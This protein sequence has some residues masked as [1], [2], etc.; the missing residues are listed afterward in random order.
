MKALFVYPEFPDTFWSFRHALKFVSKRASLPPLGLLTVAAMVP[1]HWEKRLVD[2]NV[3]RLR[4]RDIAWADCVFVSAMAV[5]R[6]AAQRLIARCQRAGKRVVAGGPLFTAE[7]EAFPEPDHLVLGEAE[8]A[9]PELVADLERGEARRVYIAPAFPELDRTPVP[10]WRLADLSRYATLSLQYSRGCPFNC[11][12][13]NVTALFGHRPRT[14]SA[15]QVI[16][17]LDALYGAGWRGGVFFV[18]DNLIGNKH[19]LKA[20]L[21]PALIAW[22][23]EHAISGFLTEASIN[24]ADDPELMD[25]MVRAGFTTVFVGIET[26]DA[27][28]LAECSKSQNAN[29]DLVADVKRIQRAGLQVQGGFIVG[30]DSDTPSIF[31]RQIAFIQQSG[32][33]TAMVGLLEALPG[34]RLFERLQREG[35]IAGATSGDNVDGTTNILPRMGLDTLREGYRRI[36]AHIYSPKHYY[37]RLKTF[38]CEYQPPKLRN[39]VTLADLR[40]FV[41]SIVRLGILGSER[42]HYWKLIVWTVLR[43][44]ELLSTAVTLAI[45]GHHF[46]KVCRLH[47]L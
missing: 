44:P 33:V 43:R 45:Y 32:I 11:D 20:E 18:D 21:L 25:L 23:R 31:E 2:L 19:R 27:A 24:L 4:D 36:L 47:V 9:L 46:R 30:F 10:L 39:R 6:A 40:A 41:R 8:G 1:E 15:A 26:P 37:A 14:K 38:L 5:Q 12:F 28:G 35:R 34:T 13:C 16:A 42:F 17:E 22:R 29:R 7:P 3:R